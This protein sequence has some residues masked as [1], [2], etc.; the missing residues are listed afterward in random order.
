VI[1]QE[2]AE[3]LSQS[4]SPETGCEYNLFSHRRN[5]GEISMRKPTFKDA[6]PVLIP[7]HCPIEMK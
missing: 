4:P 5:P 7:L 6:L 1:S 3:L 2:C